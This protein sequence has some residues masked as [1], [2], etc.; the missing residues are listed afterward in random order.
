MSTRRGLA[1]LSWA[2]VE[3]DVTC[4]EAHENTDAPQVDRYVGAGFELSCSMPGSVIHNLTFVSFG[5]PFGSC[6]D[7]SKL[8][9]NPSCEIFNSSC[10]LGAGANSNASARKAARWCS[11]GGLLGRRMLAEHMP[12]DQHHVVSAR[13]GRCR[14]LHP[15]AG[16]RPDHR[17]RDGTGHVVSH[18]ARAAYGPRQMVH[19]GCTSL[20]HKLLCQP[21]GADLSRATWH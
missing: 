16:E 14:V 10:S 12:A 11:W 13:R 1:A 6:A 21:F 17:E 7:P 4:G 3:P 8:K 9:N 19:L 5:A 20:G 2:A 18:D 15:C